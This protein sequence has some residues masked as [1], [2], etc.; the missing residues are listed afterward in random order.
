MGMKYRSKTRCSP[1]LPIITCKSL[2]EF[3]YTLEH[4]GIDQFLIHPDKFTQLFWQGKGE[5]VI[6]GW[7]LLV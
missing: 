5:Q 3:L 4:Q 7:K 6:L 2:Q 1:Q